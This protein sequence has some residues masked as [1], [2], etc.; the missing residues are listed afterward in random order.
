MFDGIDQDRSI[1]IT[2][3]YFEVHNTF[4]EVKLKLTKN[5]MEGPK[6]LLT[7]AFLYATLDQCTLCVGDY[8]PNILLIISERAKTIWHFT[9]G[10]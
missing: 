8:N 9:W 6:A 10:K 5:S 1:I 7:E 3:I 4:E 2:E